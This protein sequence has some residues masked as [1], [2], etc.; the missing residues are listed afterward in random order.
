MM[1]IILFS[2]TGCVQKEY[3]YLEAQCPRLEVLPKVTPI[4]VNVSGGCVCDANLSSLLNG[5][6]KLRDSEN[7]Y[8]EQLTKYN[9]EFVDE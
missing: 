2:L 3:I 4:D 5:A 8:M 1:V 9:K 7:Y 6:S